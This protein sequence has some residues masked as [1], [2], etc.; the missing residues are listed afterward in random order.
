MTTRGSRSGRLALALYPGWWRERY[1]DEM[2]AVLEDRPPSR[3]DLVD[4]IRGALDAHVHP[5][6]PSRVPGFA[7]ITGGTAWTV[8]AATILVQP[9]PPSWPG[10]LMDIVPLALIGVVFLAVACAGL[11]MRIAD[12]ANRLDRVALLLSIGGHVLWIA[13]LTATVTAAA[14]GP[15]LAL[16]QTAGAV[17]TLALG[18]ALIRAADASVGIMLALASL[19][20]VVPSPVAWLAFGAC[21]TAIGFARLGSRPPASVRVIGDGR[22]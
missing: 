7:A 19:A 13:A 9:V 2:S 1:G 22:W 5:D 17:G 8:I 18:L 20:L 4:L 14:D 15:T 12:P 11:W 16:A 6:V 3:S 21:W 10:Y